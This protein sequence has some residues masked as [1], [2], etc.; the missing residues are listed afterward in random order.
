MLAVFGVHADLSMTVDRPTL[1]LVCSFLCLATA[2]FNLEQT[3]SCVIGAG[4]A[5]GAQGL[6]AGGRLCP[7]CSSSALPKSELPR[8]L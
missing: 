5:R 1:K 7:L 4:L 6:L 3:A 2:A 8:N